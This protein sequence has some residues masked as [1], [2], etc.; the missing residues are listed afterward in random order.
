MNG[1]GIGEDMICLRY[2]KQVKKSK[3]TKKHQK[4]IKNHDNTPVLVKTVSSDTPESNAEA[5]SRDY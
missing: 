3:T 1:G 4:S 2:K 5:E